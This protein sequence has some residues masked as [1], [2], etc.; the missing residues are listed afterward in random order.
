MASYK[1]GYLT[2]F[3]I[4][5]KPSLKIKRETP[6][7]LKP[8]LKQSDLADT[9]FKTGLKKFCETLLQEY[10]NKGIHASPRALEEEILNTN[11]L[12]K[13][14]NSKK[15]SITK[16][17]VASSS[18]T[19]MLLPSMEPVYRQLHDKLQT[20]ENRIGKKAILIQG[21]PGIG[22]SELIRFT[23]DTMGYQSADETAATSSTKI[24][25]KIGAHLSLLEMER[26]LRK[27]YDN[28]DVAWIDELNACSL[29][30]AKILTSLLSHVNYNTGDNTKPR[31]FMLLA[32]ANG[33]DSVGRAAFS[34]TFLD[35][36]LV[37]NLSCNKKE[38]FL[39]IIQH[40]RANCSN[41]WSSQI[42]DEVAT[43]FLQLK[44]QPSFHHL[45]LR[46]LLLLIRDAPFNDWII[47][48]YSPED[49]GVTLKPKPARQ[50]FADKFSL[51]FS[52]KSHPTPLPDNTF[53]QRSSMLF[54]AARISDSSE[55]SESS[56]ICCSTARLA[57]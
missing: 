20:R 44:E 33:I 41:P 48:N 1:S 32:T 40:D 18:K 3:E 43:T 38:D 47:L 8:L 55:E 36:T 23:L 16:Q 22:K 26:C 28:G 30:I 31:G 29:G 15:F 57:S 50:R 39:A 54:K 51:F 12:G 5:F 10:R 25:H 53:T 14:N 2:K 37:V 34:P 35:R 52:R 4:I 17:I 13:H 27:A 6:G 56:L 7:I 21:V 46:D 45:N 42:I 24:Y 49:Q 19:F 9:P 11:F